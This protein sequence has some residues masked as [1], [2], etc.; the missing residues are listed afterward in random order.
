MSYFYKYFLKLFVVNFNTIHMILQNRLKGN[1]TIVIG[2]FLVLSVSVK[3]FSQQYN[4]DNQ[5]SELK[6]FGTSSL[7]DWHE[8]AEEQNGVIYLDVNGKLKINKLEIEVIAESLKSGKRGMD[9]N[10]YKA[11]KT[12]VYKSIVFQLTETK[13]ISKLSDQ[14]YKVE[15]YGDLTVAGVT[16][17]IELNFD[18]I[19][20]KD[21]LELIGEKAFN[22]TYFDIEPPKALLG[23]IKTGD[24]VVLKF[25]TIF[26]K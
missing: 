16:R 6:I 1:L 7:H 14:N 15:A 3:S 18:L 11:L 26:T 12:D 17:R 5:S 23:T 8:D 25:K 21:D 2:L 19:M 9:K 13:Q 10:T 22:M 20:N 24:E 4:L